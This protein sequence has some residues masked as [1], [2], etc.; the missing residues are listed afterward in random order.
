[1][2]FPGILLN[3]MDNKWWKPT[4]AGSGPSIHNLMMS[5]AADHQIRQLCPEDIC[6]ISK[7]VSPNPSSQNHKKSCSHESGTQLMNLY[8]LLNSNHKKNVI[9]FYFYQGNFHLVYWRKLIKIHSRTHISSPGSIL[10]AFFA[11][12]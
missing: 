5:R 11:I 10:R 9:L 2:G 6:A 4:P 8:N 3:W 7:G 1:M 12:H